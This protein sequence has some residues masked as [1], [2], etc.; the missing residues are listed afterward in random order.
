MKWR[1][2]RKKP[3]LPRSKNQR[4]SPVERIGPGYSEAARGSG[5][6]RCVAQLGCD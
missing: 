2:E 3:N 1:E 5:S 4:E 6:L